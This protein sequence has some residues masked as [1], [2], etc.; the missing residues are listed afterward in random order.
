MPVKNFENRTILGEDM[1]KSLRLTF[2]AH[3][4]CLVVVT[5]LSHHCLQF[6]LTTHQTNFIDLQRKY[7]NERNV[8]EFCVQSGV[9]QGSSLSPS[10]FNVFIDLFLSKLRQ[11]RNGCHIGS[12]FVGAILY[13]DDLI[14]LSASVSGLQRCL[15]TVCVLV[16]NFNSNLIVKIVLYCL[17]CKI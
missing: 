1:D 16:W 13:A 12:Y 8:Y 7:E 4:V 17:W 14:L 6:F 9:R 11:K 2:L 3:P 5:L 15:N 10:I